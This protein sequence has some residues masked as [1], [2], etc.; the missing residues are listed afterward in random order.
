M[1]DDDAIVAFLMDH[2]LGEDAIAEGAPRL[3][4]SELRDST[5]VFTVA[6]GE[7]VEAKDLSAIAARALDA[8]REAVA[9][10]ADH[11]FVLEEE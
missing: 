10:C 4:F 11:G 3:W 7:N 5:V 2:S 8:L 6:D 9:D 1:A